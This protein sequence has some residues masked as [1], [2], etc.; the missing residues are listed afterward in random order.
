MFKFLF[1]LNKENDHL[2][3]T[4]RMIKNVFYNLPLTKEREEKGYF[5]TRCFFRICGRWDIVK[6]ISDIN[7]GT[8]RGYDY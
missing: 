1:I 3:E 5:K 4:M 2:R 6:K 7:P 8:S